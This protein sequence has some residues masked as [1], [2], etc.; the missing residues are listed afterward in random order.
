MMLCL[1]L[2]LLREINF[3]PLSCNWPASCSHEKQTKKTKC[4]KKLAYLE[5]KQVIDHT[6]W[7]EIEHSGKE[8]LGYIR[9]MYIAQDL[10]ENQV[11]SSKFAN[12]W[13]LTRMVIEFVFLDNL[14]QVV[15]NVLWKYYVRVLLSC[16]SNSVFNKIELMSGKMFLTEQYLW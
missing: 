10:V 4:C 3:S 14:F 13:G 7:E 12:I 11:N 8:D 9:K 15:P 1:P 2:R 16:F 6:V 5:A